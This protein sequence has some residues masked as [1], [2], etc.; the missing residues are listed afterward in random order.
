MIRAV[1][2]PTP[3]PLVCGGAAVG[4]ATMGVGTA[5]AAAAGLGLDAALTTAG[6]R[7]TTGLLAGLA[8]G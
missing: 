7:T 2:P 3:L 1:D 8:A 5:G 4:A 6:G